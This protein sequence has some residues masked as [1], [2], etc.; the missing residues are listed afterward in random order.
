MTEEQQK[1]NQIFSNEHTNTLIENLVKRPE[2]SPSNVNILK[3]QTSATLLQKL[4]K[5]RTK[6]PLKMDHQD[7][8]PHGE[9][10]EQKPV[11]DE[12]AHIDDFHMP[13]FADTVYTRQ[14]YS[15]TIA[16]GKRHLF[17]KTEVGTHA[18]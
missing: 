1:W 3:L 13:S 15:N 8:V 4:F 17:K 5:T 11:F 18:K 7:N 16:G 12:T 6:I 14:H 9:A 2:A 10:V